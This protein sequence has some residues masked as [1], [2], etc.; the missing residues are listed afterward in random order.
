[1]SVRKLVI[2]TDVVLEHLTASTS[3]SVLRQAMSKFFCYT[4]VFNAIELFAIARSEP[5]LKMVEDSMAAMK[6]LGLNAKSAR[7]YGRILH[8]TR[9]RLEWKNILIAGLC[10]ESRLPILTSRKSDFRGIKGLVVIP[11]HFVTRY[12]SA[13]EIVR[14]VERQRKAH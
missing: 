11:T 12:G 4:T 3:P 10:L 1:L 14:A 6:V 2:H 9:R 7:T 13:D 5:E 8:Q